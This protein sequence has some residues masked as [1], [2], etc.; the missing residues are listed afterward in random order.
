VDRCSN[1]HFR[2]LRVSCGAVPSTAPPPNRPHLWVVPTAYTAMW[3]FLVHYYSLRAQVI[4]IVVRFCRRSCTTTPALVNLPQRKL[5]VILRSGKLFSRHA[6][7]RKV[8][9]AY[10]TNPTWS[11]PIAWR[12]V[13][14]FSPIIAFLSITVQGSYLPLE[15]INSEEG[16]CNL[17]RNGKQHSTLNILEDKS[18]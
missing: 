3:L 11:P 12:S 4:I 10:F 18:V 17:C 13:L 5:K 9:I 2:A 16:K 8:S 6:V 14:L 15:E 1:P 7:A